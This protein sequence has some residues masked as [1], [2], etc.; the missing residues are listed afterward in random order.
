MGFPKGVTPLWP[1]EAIRLFFRPLAAE[2]Y[3]LFPLYS[4]VPDMA[5]DRHIVIIGGGVSGM[6][7]ALVLKRHGC[8]SLIVEKK[9]R[10]GSTLRGFSRQGTHFDTGLHYAGGLDERGAL[11][12]YFR[13]LGMTD[14]PLADFDP[15]GFDR[16]RFVKEGREIALPIGYER[17]IASLSDDFPHDAAFIASF[18]E[19]VRDAF[20]SSSFLNFSGGLREA[21]DDSFKQ[22]SLARVLNAGT[23]N[24]VLKTVLS[25]HALLYGVPPDE[26]PFIQHARIAGS[27]LEGVKT[28]RGGGK[29][30][31]AAFEARLDQEG[32]GCILDV[33]VR[34]LSFS[35]AGGVNGVI[36]DDGRFFDADGVIFTAHPALLPDMLDGGPARVPF[37]RRFTQLEDTFSSFMLF[38]KSGTDL[39]SLRGNNL[40]ICP[41]TDISPAFLSDSRT[42]DGP[43]YVTKAFADLVSADTEPADGPNER[44]PGLIAFA[45][46]RANEVA[47]WADSRTGKRPQAYLD[48]KRERLDSLRNALVGFCP[49]LADVRFID[50]GTPLTNR[51][52]LGAPGCGLYGTKHS[53]NQFSP[54]PATRI[55]NLWLAGQSVVAPGIL[56]AII[57]AFLACGFV[58]GMES[59]R[60]EITAC[61]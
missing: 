23:S 14:L 55:P 22:E 42:E 33:G 17:I 30:L 47:A 51:D 35:P 31:A 40:F 1:P 37:L 15:E 38:G 27:Y 56:G 26:T 4:K 12:R 21:V 24:P 60:K 39:P 11:T 5:R 25:I 19:R 8:S 46:G 32:I 53:L 28:I 57:S 10:L 2:G 48:F 58:V 6:A 52:Y 20:R 34:K 16:I 9:R 3:S 54:L 59:L 13:L 7:A 61:A 45:P 36:L 29:T 18:Y 41:K 44:T 43:F 49:E 50:G